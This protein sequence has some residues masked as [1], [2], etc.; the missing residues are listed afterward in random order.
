MVPKKEKKTKGR[1]DADEDEKAIKPFPGNDLSP[2]GSQGTYLPIS[3]NFLQPFVI[4]AAL[5]ASLPPLDLA[6]AST[7]GATF[8]V[9]LA[10]SSRPSILTADAREFESHLPLR[11]SSAIPPPSLACCLR[12]VNFVICEDFSYLP[13]PWTSCCSEKGSS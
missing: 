1:R 7:D 4:P 9:S 3:P 12:S 10:A 5:P 6:A 8:H 2:E 11:L 13:V